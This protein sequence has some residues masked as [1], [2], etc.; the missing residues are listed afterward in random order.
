MYLKVFGIEGPCV[1]DLGARGVDHL[2]AA[3]PETPGSLAYSFA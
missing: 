3:P 2:H 1:Y